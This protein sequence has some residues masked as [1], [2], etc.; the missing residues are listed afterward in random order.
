MADVFSI[1][2]TAKYNTTV[3]E[4]IQEENHRVSGLTPQEFLNI[5]DTFNVTNNEKIYSAYNP[6]MKAQYEEEFLNNSLSVIVPNTTLT[7]PLTNTKIENI[8]LVGDN[9]FL[10]QKDSISFFSDNY[11]ELISNDGFIKSDNLIVGGRAVDAKIINENIRVWV[12]VRTLDKIINLSPFISILTTI[13][14]TMTLS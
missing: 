9:Q 14:V 4:Y 1:R 2:Y 13:P 6:I 7:L 5:R 12:W 8:V 3:E 10:E 11:N